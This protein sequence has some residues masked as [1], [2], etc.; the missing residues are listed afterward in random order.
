MS[1]INDNLRNLQYVNF[2]NST[3]PW[4]INTTYLLQSDN[5]IND[6]SYSESSNN[7]LYIESNSNNINLK[8]SESKKIN[9]LGDIKSYNNVEIS[10]SLFV[11][12]DISYNRYLYLP[13]NGNDV[14]IIG[15]LNLQGTINQ[16]GTG[17]G[18]TGSTFINALIKKSLLTRDS[19]TGINSKINFTDICLCTINDTLI[20][21]SRI[22][23]TEIGVGNS[24]AS[25]AAF[26]DVSINY[27]DISN[28]LTIKNTII[29]QTII[30]NFD[31]LTINNNL[32]I[33]GDVSCNTLKYNN[34]DPEISIVN[35]SDVSLANIEICGNMFPSINNNFN[36]GNN[37]NLFN[38][39]YL[40]TLYINNIQNI[41]NNYI[42]ITSISGINISN[43]DLNVTN[44]V[45]INQTLCADIITS[46]SINPIE[47]NSGY[48]NIGLI[49]NPWNNAY[50]SNISANNITIENSLNVINSISC[51]SINT[52]LLNN[53]NIANVNFNDINSLPSNVKLNGNIN[54]NGDIS[55][56]NSISNNLIITISNEK[57][58][59]LEG[60]KIYES[61]LSNSYITIPTDI[62]LYYYIDI[63]NINNNSNK[64]SSVKFNYNNDISFIYEFN[65]NI[66]LDPSLIDSNYIFSNNTVGN[67]NNLKIKTKQNNLENIVI[68][69]SGDFSKLCVYELYDKPKL[70]YEYIITSTDKKL[71][72]TEQS[73][74]ITGQAVA[75]GNDNYIKSLTGTFATNLYNSISYE[76]LYETNISSSDL[77]NSDSIIIGT[78]NI[79]YNYSN[80]IVLLGNYLYSHGNNITVLGNIDC[81]AWHPPRTNNVDLGSNLYKF[82]TL[83][84]NE[85]YCNKIISI[86]DPSCYI[87]FQNIQESEG[88]EI[89]MNSKTPYST[90]SVSKQ[91]NGETLI[92][93][94]GQDVYSDDRL[95]HNEASIINSLS[96]I[97]KLN[98]QV[99]DMTNEFYDASYIGTISGDYYHRAGFIAQEIRQIEELSYC[100][101]GE[102]YDTNGNPTPLAIDYNSIFTHGI[103][104]IQELNNIIENQRIQIATLQSENIN[105][106][107][108]ISIMKSALNTLLRANDLSNI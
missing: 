38:E 107:N 61:S 20:Y 7:D 106:N 11:N 83:Y 45:N 46:T 22:Y 8:V 10:N 76:F 65:N 30:D 1:I 70:I 57:I 39:A 104:A 26:T 80:D 97:N 24:N 81:S 4:K 5:S 16:T 64:N 40:D 29:E 2:N 96:I 93:G 77:S 41:S 99:Y 50:I 95:K 85:I 71:F 15:N 44:N 66:P 43:C 73:I 86:E 63:S 12:N 49:N 100:C 34:L 68:T 27:L 87:V 31:Y 59:Y 21:D 35:F 84:V 52:T 78:N 75:Q 19:T 62:N 58:N 25:K 92:R 90:N 60:I 13:N 14:N 91:P 6:L 82:N 48:N 17:I 55:I 32:N 98:P 18:D 3:V 56:N 37:S 79:N 42:N 36:I 89:W 88:D 54:I 108:E 51:N 103:Q 9:L 94:I 23:N 53:Y 102:E 28:S 69:T 33:D 105:L 72:Y 74:V 101:I 47:I 67:Y